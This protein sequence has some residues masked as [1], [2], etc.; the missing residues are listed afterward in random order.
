ME[1]VDHALRQRRDRVT[2]MLELCTS[3]TE[4]QTQV[5]LDILK[6]NA[7]S[8]YGEKY[9]FE[10]I[11]SIGAWQEVPLTNYNLSEERWPGFWDDPANFTVDRLAAY[12]MTSGSTA[13]PKKIPVTSS[14]VREKARAF[15]LFWDSIYATHPALVC[16]NFIANF[17]DSG[18]I[19]RDPGNVTM[20]S[21]TTF[22]NKRMQG[23]QDPER[24]PLGKRLTDIP[25]SADRYY[26]AARLALQGPLHCMMSLNPSTLVKFCQTIDGNRDALADG[27]SHGTWGGAFDAA[28]KNVPRAV[29]DKLAADEARARILNSGNSPS[30]A[31]RLQLA[32]IW[33]ELELIICWQSALVEPYLNLLREYTG[34]IA[35]RDYITQSSEC[36]IAVPMQ[37]NE[38]GGLL[39]F[40]SHFYEF[41]PELEANNDEPSVLTAWELETGARY[42]PVVTTG[43]GLYRYR[44][45]DCVRVK[46][47]IGDAPVLEF[48]CRL[49]NTSSMTGEKLTEMQV[50]AAFSAANQ[51]GPVVVREAIVFP[52][53][54]EQPH[55]A[56]LVPQQED[57][58]EV[59]RSRLD[60]WLASFEKELYRVN[61]EYKDKRESLR[62]G[63]LRLLLVSEAD[64]RRIE[65][66]FKPAHIGDDQFK[67]AYLRKERDLDRDFA[68]LDEVRARS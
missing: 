59:A 39:A 5:L 32:N 48:Q 56:V 65:Q 29:T 12:F 13:R 23:F 67:P 24:W 36:A 41:I 57:R 66:K 27:L 42:E 22:W 7:K 40:T 3:I 60:A 58:L 38:S 53:T 45:G 9:R 15:G 62:L 55:Y 61:G 33:P 11:R 54:V 37:D 35:F 10:E 34:D 8:R 43:G 47:F 21:E 26:A 51:R 4:I 52:R 1:S 16:G 18:V 28:E 50:L 49:G 19:V 6:H 17:A 14:L 46:R 25:N 68:L 20:M 2:A 64:Y 63:D 30:S 44:T 31:S